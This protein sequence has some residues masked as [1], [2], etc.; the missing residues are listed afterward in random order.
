MLKKSRLCG[1]FVPAMNGFWLGY[2]CTE[3][4]TLSMLQSL[5][6]CFLEVAPTARRSNAS[7][8]R[9]RRRPRARGNSQPF[10]ALSAMT[11]PSTTRLQGRC[12][13][14][15]HQARP[16][17]PSLFEHVYRRG[18]NFAEFPAH[19]SSSC[20][21]SVVLPPGQRSTNQRRQDLPPRCRVADPKKSQNQPDPVVATENTR[22]PCNARPKWL[23][24][25]VLSWIR[26]CP[27]TCGYRLQQLRCGPCFGCKPTSK[28]KHWH[29][30]R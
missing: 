12:Y 16:Q 2:K 19:E 8:P 25:R 6:I 14:A 3:G 24:R 13:P 17:P 21:R 1:G 15:D 30:S 5:A 22:E 10:E 20:Q 26:S 18:F 28:T 23:L 9:K 7:F 29:Q 4:K 27:T 11:T